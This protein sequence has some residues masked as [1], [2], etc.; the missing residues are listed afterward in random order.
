MD[1]YG[2]W[3]INLLE[4]NIQFCKHVHFSGRRSTTFKDTVFKGNSHLPNIRKFCVT[5]MMASLGVNKAEGIKLDR[6]TAA[7]GLAYPS[8]QQTKAWEAWKF[9]LPLNLYWEWKFGKMSGH[10]TIHQLWGTSGQVTH[11]SLVSVSLYEKWASHSD[12]KIFS[13]SVL[14][15]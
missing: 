3:S 5:H 9:S 7:N 12:V 15:W 8:R 13:T 2:G 1:D 4:V 11:H 14:M 10:R 6:F